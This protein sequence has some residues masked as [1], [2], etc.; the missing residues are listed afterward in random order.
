MPKN[1]FLKLNP[2][3]QLSQYTSMAFEPKE[4]HFKSIQ[5]AHIRGQGMSWM[6]RMR[7][8]LRK[9][10]I[11]RSCALWEQPRCPLMTE[12]WTKK[13]CI[14]TLEYYPVIE[15]NKIVSFATWIELEIIIL[16]DVSQT[17]KEKYCMTSRTCWV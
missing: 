3:V 7:S 5:Q 6:V 13:W 14:Y 8:G 17:E 9:G 2:L 15:K 11:Q 12:E 4:I 10:S 16:S 1:P